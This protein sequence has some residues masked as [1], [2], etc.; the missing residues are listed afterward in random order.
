MLYS[1]L[2]SFDALAGHPVYGHSF[3]GLVIENVVSSLPAGWRASFFRTARGA[4]IDLVLEKGARRVAIEC[5]ASAAPELESGFWSA[6]EELA[7]EQ[8]LLVAPIA[9][10]FPISEDILVVSPTEAAKRAAQG[11]PPQARSKQRPS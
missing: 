4:E 5:K 3:E 10:A 2:D 9:E 11:F 7:F 1:E 6:R 8:T